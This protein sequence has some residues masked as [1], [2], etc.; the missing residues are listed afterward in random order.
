MIMAIKP[1]KMDGKIV[2]DANSIVTK[3]I[4]FSN[5]LSVSSILSAF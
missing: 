2:D 3:I 4:F 5:I 1:P